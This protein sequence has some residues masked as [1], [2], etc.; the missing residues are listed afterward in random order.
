MVFEN[1]WILVI[2][3][4]DMSEFKSTILLFLFLLSLS[5]SP[6]FPLSCLPLDYLN[7][8]SP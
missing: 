5:F 7:L 1:K 6:L 8:S 4:N 2:S 3:M